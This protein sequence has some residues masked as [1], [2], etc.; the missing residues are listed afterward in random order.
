[1]GALQW[2]HAVLQHG[3]RLRAAGRGVFCA[4]CSSS[5]Q[6][7]S[8]PSPAAPRH[9]PGDPRGEGDEVASGDRRCLDLH[10]EVMG[11]PSPGG[12]E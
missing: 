8:L 1:M 3:Q 2:W 11:G 4:P 10:S 9:L 12:P 7:N 6:F 5:P